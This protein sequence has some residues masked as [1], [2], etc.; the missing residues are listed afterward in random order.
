MENRTNFFETYYPHA[1][2]YLVHQSKARFKGIAAGARSGKTFCS[3]KE[4]MKRII[5]DMHTKRSKL[6]LYWVVAPTSALVKIALR[7]VASTLAGYGCLEPSSLMQFV[8]GWHKSENRLT[9]FNGRVIIWFKSADRPDLLVAEGLDGLWID[10]AA[11]MKADAWR[12]N[13]RMRLSDKN[14]WCL[15]SSTPKGP[16]WYY[17]D[18]FLRGVKGSECY[19]PEFES[20]HF[21][22]IDNTAVP[23]LVEEVRKARNELP[24]A[25]FEREY[26]ANFDAFF[27]QIYEELD[28]SIHVID[29][30]PK[31]TRFVHYSAGMDYG[32]NQG[33]FGIDGMTSTGDWICLEEITKSQLVVASEDSNAPSWVN[34]I[35]QKIFDVNGDLIYPGLTIWCDSADPEAIKLMQKSGLP[36]RKAH[37]E[38]LN[39]I[40]RVASLLHPV[41]GRGPN[42]EAQPRYRF[43]RRC[44]ETYRQMVAYHWD[45]YNGI[46]LDRPA[47]RQTDHHADEKRYSLYSD[48]VKGGKKEQRRVSGW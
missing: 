23:G 4:L 22:T 47:P 27:G 2:Q 43:L 1:K 14:G 45:E 6:L 16:N 11:R 26:E 19:D 17:T 24:K 32:W 3:G 35:K 15:F 40:A 8:E 29:A 41:P 10:E 9:I 37:K 31:G 46:S 48:F 30:V 39:G 28:E 25:Y 38:V 18:V 7:E 44:K 20:F 5:Y 12:G 42:G 34:L 13:L 36:A 21:K 33:A